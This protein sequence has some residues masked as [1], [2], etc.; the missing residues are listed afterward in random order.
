MKRTV[1]EGDRINMTQRENNVDKPLGTADWRLARRLVT[2]LYLNQKLYTGEDRLAHADGMADIL[3]GVR[4]DEELICAAYLFSVADCV[5]DPEDWIEKTFGKVVLQLVTDLQRLVAVSQRARGGSREADAAYQPEALRRMLLAMCHDLRVVVLRLASRLQTL[6]WFAASG[7]SGASD[8]G[9]ETLAL[10][11]PLANRLGIW[12]MKWELEDLSL[13]FTEPKIYADIARELDESREERLKFMQD[14]VDRIK[15]LLRQENIQAQVSGR[16]KHIYSIYKKMVRKHLRFDQLFD[17]RAMRIIVD[18]VEHCYEVLSIVQKHF[19]VLSKEY[20]DYI[21]HPKPNGYQSLHTVVTDPSGKPVEIQIRTQAM[22]EFAE[23]GVAA[24]WRYK[25]TGNSNKDKGAE[26]EEQRV[27]WLRQILAW[28][29]DVEP[30]KKPGLEDDHVYALTPQGRVVELP[31]GATP[32]DFAYQV[33][34]ELG[35]RCR[36]ARVNGVMVPLNTKLKTGE[37]VEIITVKTGGPSRDWLN[38]ELGF[39]VSPR[40]RTKV[41]QWFNAQTLAEMIA[42]GREKLDRELAR[43]GKTAVKLEDLAKRLGYDDVDELCVAFYKEE[44]SSRSIEQALTP[45]QPEPASEPPVLVRTAQKGGRDNVLVVGMGSLLTQLARCCHPTPPDEIV[46][47]V[48]R[49]RGVTIHRIDCPN[50]KNLA[51]N[52]Q[53]RM[54]EVSWGEATDAVYPIDILVVARDRVGLIK[55]ISEVFLR[56]KLNIIGI[57]TMNV[58]GDA[59]M[60]FSVE[61]RSSEEIQRALAALR[62]LNGVMSV[63]RA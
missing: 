41:R 37:T 57:N 45:P 58:K 29:S 59:H 33:H 14:C 22:H 52:I 7:A 3:R 42:N 38:P 28:H 36:G 24:H 12:Q 4:E 18:T 46:G 1:S 32:I 43:L 31:G 44:L 15:L 51:A 34:T 50:A 61:V 20:D 16:P 56:E 21:A 39:A 11:S 47:F 10:Y 54:I 35:H 25:E 9:R 49:G 40:T 17:I 55:D 5:H 53:E 48:T 6:R 30:P 19:T 23:L 26:A 60:R 63:R 8:Y 27:A 2:P 13:R 62:E